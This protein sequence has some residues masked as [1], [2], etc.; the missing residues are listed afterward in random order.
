MKKNNMYVG[1]DTD[2]NSIDVAIGEEGRS[3]EV[4]HYG[5]IENNLSAIDKLVRKLESLGHTLHIVYEAG[6]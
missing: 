3:K 6:P 1:M 2:K 4:R 5:R